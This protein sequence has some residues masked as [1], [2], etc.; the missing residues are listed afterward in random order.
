MKR[1]LEFGIFVILAVTLHILAFAKGPQSGL[2]AGGSGGE[3]M[4][5]IQAALPTV[6][7]M[8]KTWE[9]PPDINPTVQSEQATPEVVQTD[10]LTVPQID[11]NPAPNAALQV[12]I[13]QPEIEQSIEVE[14]APP[15]PPPPPEPEAEA[16]PL[17]D[18]RPKPRPVKEQPKEGIKAPQASAGRQEEVSAGSGGSTQ[19]GLG[20][21]KVTTGDPGKT[22][23]LTAVWGAK[24]R[25]RIDRSKRYP[26]GSRAN[27]DVTIELHVARDGKLVSYRMRKSSGVPELDDAAMKAVARAKRFPKAPKEL[28]GNSFKFSL[29]IMLQ[30]PR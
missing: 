25:A 21:A 22:A 3:A 28:V 27:G 12:A 20:N 13:M 2:Q 29:S 10:T 8:V 19:A 23:Q 15:P 17:P 14:T 7:D 9:R 18:T 30:S 6:V 24:I 1:G 11:L 26:H 4:V 5:S 16:E